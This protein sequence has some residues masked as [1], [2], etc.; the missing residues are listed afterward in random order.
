[1]ADGGKWGHGWL[2]QVRKNNK[3]GEF[4]GA[5]AAKQKLEA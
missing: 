4:D 5:A 3:F 1:V 2:T